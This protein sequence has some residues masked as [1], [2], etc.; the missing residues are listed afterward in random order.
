MPNSPSLASDSQR[1]SKIS[2]LL[3]RVNQRT[4]NPPNDINLDTNNLDSASVTSSVS[5]FTSSSSV[6]T[7]SDGVE[8][9]YRDD[10]EERHNESIMSSAISN[11]I[12]DKENSNNH[13]HRSKRQKN[14][15][16]DSASIGSK[17][18]LSGAPVLAATPTTLPLSQRKDSRSSAT[19]PPKP[20]PVTEKNARNKSKSPLKLASISL[21]ELQNRF[22][23]LVS[24]RGSLVTDL[25][26]TH[27][28]LE[29]IRR[30]KSKL[31]Q[32]SSKERN[33]L[34]SRIRKLESEKDS[35][36]KMVEKRDEEIKSLT[37]L[38]TQQSQVIE[39]QKIEISTLSQKVHLVQKRT[40]EIITAERS[41]SYTQLQRAE[42]RANV[43]VE[44]SD[45]SRA[46][47]EEER[48]NWD[49]KAAESENALEVSDYS[50][51]Y[52]NHEDSGR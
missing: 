1:S 16:A 49:E 18:K 28:Q 14:L 26:S 5:H 25:E 41:N 12:D 39:N 13:N 36:L 7:S 8:E 29:E 37:K 30:E 34:N 11:S 9:I 48:K 40:R 33:A 20:P 3:S 24:E 43:S 42:H 52:G 19:T 17:R 2:A 6:N 21:P 35:L 45:F 23:T 31:M 46:K 51:D 10:E 47:F 38:T 27:R 32:R 15:V 22:R 44:R 4:N 50:N